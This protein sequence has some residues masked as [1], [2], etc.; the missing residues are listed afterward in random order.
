MKYLLLILSLTLA[1]CNWGKQKAKETANKTGQMVSEAGSEF[2]DGVS[3]GIE[4]TFE[5]QVILSEEL[6]SKGLK[7]GKILIRGTDSTT[8]NI[9]SVYFIFDKPLDQ[10]ITIKIISQQ[11]QEYGRLTWPVKGQ[12]GEAKYI[13]YVFDKRTNIDGKGKL[14]FE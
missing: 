5:N 11:E 12:T 10:N 8:D 13:D 3:K 9:L 2:V 4:K 14:V 1:S 7:T 6:K